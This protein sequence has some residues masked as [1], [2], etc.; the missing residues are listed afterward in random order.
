MS[1]LKELDIKN[2]ISDLMPFHQGEIHDSDNL[3]A[4]GLDSMSI[5]KLLNQWRSTG[6]NVSFAALVEEPTLAAWKNK[7][8]G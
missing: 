3:I 1:K 8:L 6:A 7:L 5:L 2:Q 4:L